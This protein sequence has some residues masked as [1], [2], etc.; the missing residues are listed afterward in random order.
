MSSRILSVALFA[1]FA[2][3]GLAGCSSTPPKSPDVTDSLH[4]SLDQAGLKDV[5]VSQDRDK[6]VVT[7]GGKVMSDADKTQAE[8]IAKAIAGQQVV[9]DL[10]IV[11]PPGNESNAKEVNSDL[12]KGIKDNFDA[13]LVGHKHYSDVKYE[14]KNGVITLTGTVDSQ[15]IRAQVE[16]LAAGVPNVKQVVNELEMKNVKAT[17]TQK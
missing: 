5:T 8:S 9:A 17:T 4:R 14:V 10:I 2:I 16:T 12:D 13:A 3:G 1:T 15:A 6:G 7:L 11:L